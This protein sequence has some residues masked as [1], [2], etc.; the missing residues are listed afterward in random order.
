MPNLAE[1]KNRIHSTESTRKITQ[2]MQLV[3]ANKMKGF[4]KKALSTREYAWKLIEGLAMAHGSFKNTVYGE[5]RQ[6]GKI[7]YILVT[8]DKGLA[9]SLNTRLIDA[10][11]KSDDW[12][13]L[14]ENDRMLITIGKKS[15][16]AARRMKVPV[17][18]RFDGLSEQMDAFDALEIISVIL[19]LWEEKEVKQVIFVSPHYVNPFTIHITRKI[20]LPFDE[21]MLQT[22]FE[23]FP[24]SDAKKQKELVDQHLYFE[25]NED[26]I[27]DILSL[28]LV[29]TLFLQAFFELKASEYSS[30]MVAM[31]Q[32]TEAADEMI[33]NLT[34]EYNKVRQSIITQQLAELAA[35]RQ[36]LGANS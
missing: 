1:V 31:K 21:S 28:Q 12:K 30:R 2:A 10:L 14:S 29:Q 5:S 18:R 22:H 16:E 13:S 6:E 24:K 36:A 25:P 4:Q 32:A 35:G 11:F 34:L 20:Y 17:H 19:G 9:G 7:L 26:D 8:S 27:I 3:A 33:E 15:A 23:W